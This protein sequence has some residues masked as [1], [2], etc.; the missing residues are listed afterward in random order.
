MSI[1]VY[2]KPGCSDCIQAKTLI[3][4]KGESYQ[5]V[6]LSTPQLV[7]G[8]KENFPAVRGMPHIL[9]NGIEINGLRGLKEYYDN[10]KQLLT[11]NG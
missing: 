11:E 6:N 9:I 2:T 5:E 4:L 8:F 10:R 7:E 1:V 3:T